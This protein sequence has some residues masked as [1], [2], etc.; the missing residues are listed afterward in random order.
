MRTLL[1]IISMMAL[2]SAGLSAQAQGPAGPFGPPEGR[3]RDRV[4]ERIKTIKVWKLTDELNLSQ[5]Q[6]EKFFPVYNR[7]FERLEEIEQEKR[8]VMDRLVDATAESKP[9]EAEIAEIRKYLDRLDSLDQEIQDLKVKFRG[10]LKNILTELQIGKLYLFEF[11]FRQQM[12][13]IMRDIRR[14][15][16]RPHFDRN[17]DK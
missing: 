1:K 13:E 11:R 10:E 7:N 12:Q 9:D 14:E 17:Q 8:K 4:R 2:L 15:G 16:G 5:A 6:S 3:M